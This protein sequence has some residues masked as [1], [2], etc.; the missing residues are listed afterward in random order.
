MRASISF[1]AAA[2]ALA[3]ILMVGPASAAASGI[4]KVT[5][6][7]TTPF[8]RGMV[9]SKQFGGTRS[10]ERK[11]VVKVYKRRDGKDQLI[12]VDT[13]SNEGRWIVPDEPT[14]GSYYAKLMPRPAA[15]KP[16]CRSDLSS[17]VTIGQA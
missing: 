9:K 6:S 4:S 16:A 13:S 14:A 11:R 15:R 12:G 7:E 8:W 3:C 17:N 1:I 5:L 2:L 10:C